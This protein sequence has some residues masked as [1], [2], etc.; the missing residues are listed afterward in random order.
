MLLPVRDLNEPSHIIFL[1]T[2]IRPKKVKEK[3]PDSMTKFK[4]ISYFCQ[5]D[6][7]DLSIDSQCSQAIR[8]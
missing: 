6:Y 8:A 7:T 2:E 5:Q 4:Y 3:H 1:E